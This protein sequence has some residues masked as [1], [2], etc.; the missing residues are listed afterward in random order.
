MIHRFMVA[1]A[2]I[3]FTIALVGCAHEVNADAPKQIED[4]VNDVV[5]GDEIMSVSISYQAG[6]EDALEISSFDCLEAEMSSD[7]NISAVCTSADALI[8][9]GLFDALP[10][11]ETCTEI[12]GGSDIATVTVSFTNGSAVNKQFSRENGC[13]IGE[14]DA[15]YAILPA[16]KG[17]E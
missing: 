7:S 8:A 5:I 12:Y 11:D 13:R 17:I 4:K 16:P 3:F 10:A 9:N 14:W 2:G 1:A 15:A 6:P